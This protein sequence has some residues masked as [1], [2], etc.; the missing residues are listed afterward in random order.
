MTAANNAAAADDFIPAP[1]GETATPAESPGTGTL[2]GNA[3]ELPPVEIGEGIGQTELILSLVAVLVLAGLLFIL[4]NVIRRSLIAGRATIDS[5][6]AAA[7]SWYISL[8]GFAALVVAGI[9]A[10][11]FGS[12]EYILLTAAVL[13]IGVLISLKMTSR[14]KRSA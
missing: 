13:L 9:A 2:A 11:L 7:W 10:D 3:S 4:K 1:E 8:L 14:A 6:N 12:I 5:A